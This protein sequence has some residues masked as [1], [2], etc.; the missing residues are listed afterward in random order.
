MSRHQAGWGGG[1]GGMEEMGRGKGKLNEKSRRNPA[2]PPPPPSRDLILS[3]ARVETFCMLQNGGGGSSG[4]HQ[5]L[6]RDPFLAT[7]ATSLAVN[8]VKLG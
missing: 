4:K 8:K 7:G 3:P 6:L 5:P 2:E 1:V